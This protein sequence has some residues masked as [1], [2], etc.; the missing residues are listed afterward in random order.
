MCRHIFPLKLWQQWLHSFILPNFGQTAIMNTDKDASVYYTAGS[1]YDS[2]MVTTFLK[3]LFTCCREHT[4]TPDLVIK[5]NISAIKSEVDKLNTGNCTEL[6]SAYLAAVEDSL[7]DAGVRYALIYKNG[8]PALFVY[9]Q[10]F[11][12]STRHFNLQQNKGFM[13]HILSLLLSVKKAKVLVLGNALRTD[14][15]GFS[16]D[17]HAMTREEAIAAVAGIAEK[18]SADEHAA[19]V[20]L[21]DLPAITRGGQKMLAGMGYTKPWDDQVME[22]AINPEWHT[23][24]DYTA[25]LTR[26]YKTRANKVLAAAGKL[27]TK[28]MDAAEVKHYQPEINKLFA[29][30]VEK[31]SF[32]LATAGAGNLAKLKEIYQDSFEV[33]GIFMDNSLVAF[34]SAFINEDNYELYY[35][36]FDYSLNNEYQLYFNILFS[37][38]ERGIIL[39]KK[40]LKLGRTSFD[41]K[42]SIGATAKSTDYRIKFLYI[43]DVA[44]KWFASYFT[45]LED[46]K[47]KL[48][49]PLKNNIADA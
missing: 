36:G 47:W 16:F 14:T 39:K 13:K 26:K 34:Y 9:F 25:V 5:K 6:S 46:G 22:M 30:L 24:Q 38:L 44:V 15:Q 1:A 4:D 10:L 28:V 8:A 27:V 19:A 45:A 12:L 17:A 20:I 35:I 32:T 23:L 31:Q 29:T 41:A 43:P 7:P 3:N 40:L 48:R 42:A 21:K 2:C 49:N 18:L 11:S 33:S 37:G